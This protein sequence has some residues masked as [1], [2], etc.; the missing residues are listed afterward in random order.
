M[1]TGIITHKGQV[2]SI[3]NSGDNNSSVYFEIGVNSDFVGDIK[4]GDSIA[5][6]GTC[7][8][9]ISFDSNSF[10]LQ[11]I[12]ET[13]ARTSFLTTT[14]GDEVNLEKALKMSQ[15][16]DGHIVQGHIDGV[17]IV[18]D[19]LQQQDNWVLSINVPVELHKYVAYKGSITLNG[20]S[21]TISK[22]TQ[23]GLQVSLIDHTLDNTN[24]KNLIVGSLVN[25]EI[26][27]IARY[28][29]NMIVK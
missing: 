6:N 4:L 11:L 17:G 28:V 29:E 5:V 25:V 27:V 21:L 2:K 18:E 22:K 19:Y 9:V 10:R 15:R 7:L 24:L 12:P 13:I 26:D 16:L 20:V 23:N 14:I 3:A 1:F 8:T